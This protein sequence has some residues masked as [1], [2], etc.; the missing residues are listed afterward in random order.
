MSELYPSPWLHAD[1]LQGRTVTVTVARVTIEDVR[2]RDGTTETR[3][4]LSFVGK[5]KR[6]ICN[7]TQC[8]ALAES[9]GSEAFADWGRA[10]VTLRPGTAPNGKPTIVIERGDHD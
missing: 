9:T 7:K 6:L 1:D 4:V 2:Q 8:E 3:A 5:R 10:T